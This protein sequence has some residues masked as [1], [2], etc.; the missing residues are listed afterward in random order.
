[1]ETRAWI[2]VVIKLYEFYRARPMP[3]D[4]QLAYW[5]EQVSDIPDSA[6]GQCIEIVTREN[7]RLPDNIP[8]AIREAYARLP[9]TAGILRCYDPVEDLRFPVGLLHEGLRVLRCDGQEAFA[10]YAKR[11]GMPS[12]DQD[13]VR[14]KLRVQQGAERDHLA[15]LR[16]T[17][18]QIGKP[19]PKEELDAAPR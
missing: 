12:C 4:S 3:S 18:R 10:R 7:K 17:L 9:K 8:L 14:V 19:M 15:N 1:M 5:W 13:R 16:K 2:A 6:L 11:V